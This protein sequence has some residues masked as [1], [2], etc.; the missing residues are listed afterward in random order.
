MNKP[1]I[2]FY[3][4]LKPPDHPIP[5]GDRRM[6]ANLFAALKKGGCEVFLASRYICYS[7]RWD[8]EFFNLRKQGA[9][10]EAERLIRHWQTENIRPDL[11]FCF[12]NYCKA[13]DWVGMDVCKQLKIPLI[14][15]KP[16]KT[17]QGPNSEWDEWRVEAQKSIKMAETSIVMTD[18]DKAYLET[19]VDK[20]KLFWMPPFLDT[21]L[22]KTA[23]GLE[24]G[25]R[26]AGLWSGGLKLFTPAMM[27]PGAKMESYHI[28]SNALSLLD[29][30][31]W[32]LVIAGGGP[33]FDEVAAM[34]AWDKKNRVNLIGEVKSEE[35]FH[36]IDQADLLAWPGWS[37]AYGMVYLEAA[38]RGCPVVALNHTGVPMVVEH[39]RSGLLA[40]PPD[41]TSYAA[42]LLRLMKD[43]KLLNKLATGAKEF[44]D[45][46]RSGKNTAKQLKQV[47][48]GVLETHRAATK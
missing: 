26:A 35:I 8:E 5:S 31:D 1:L 10:K 42:C 27:R 47:I 37:E 17:G 23:D 22:L 19:L 14:H 2:A 4:P 6:G 11:W 20:D 32:S 39:E 33:G 3:A 40:S 29:D 48:D 15:A 45:A 46:E 41:A 18:N 12:H 36:L 24:D 16:C 34:F 25:R 44:F 30:Q 43:R 7:K 28:L 21:E 38:S 13:P 9:I